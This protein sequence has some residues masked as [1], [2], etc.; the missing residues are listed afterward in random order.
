MYVYRDSVEM[1]CT[2]IMFGQQLSVQDSS[3]SPTIHYNSSGSVKYRGLNADYKK[4]TI[5]VAKDNANKYNCCQWS[6]AANLLCFA[7]RNEAD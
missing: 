3:P 4:W 5:R 6:A 2:E 1:T 7:L